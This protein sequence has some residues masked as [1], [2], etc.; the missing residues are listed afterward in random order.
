M[1]DL[2]I[3]ESDRTVV[4]PRWY[5][6]T[7]AKWSNMFRPGFVDNAGGSRGMSVGEV[8]DMLIHDYGVYN[9]L[10]LDGGASTGLWVRGIDDVQL[11]DSFDE[12]PVV[13]TVKS[14]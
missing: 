12:V 10:N 5:V 6:G 2:A 1:A 7:C 8:A 11:T 9:A 14:A 13:I 3:A 4:V